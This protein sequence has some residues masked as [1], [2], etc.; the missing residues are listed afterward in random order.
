MGGTRSSIEHDYTFGGSSP[1]GS[2]GGGGPSALSGLRTARAFTFYRDADAPASDNAWASG[3]SASPGF[4][5]VQAN[6]PALSYLTNTGSTDTAY[7][8]LAKPALSTAASGTRRFLLQ[9]TLEPQSAAAVTGQDWFMGFGGPL[10][11]NLWGTGLANLIG[12]YKPANGDLTATVYRSLASP[13]LP[14]AVTPAK[15]FSVSITTRPID[16]SIVV[17]APYAGG[18]GRLIVEWFVDQVRYASYDAEGVSLTSA[19]PIWG[20]RNTTSGAKGIYLI[21]AYY[22]LH[23]VHI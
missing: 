17:T 14:E 16:F 11:A 6:A 19:S 9:W 2:A 4:S 20:L 7:L 12:F 8:T 23:V 5:V 10:P 1:F 3:G 18:S 13:V 22:A 21:S 15:T